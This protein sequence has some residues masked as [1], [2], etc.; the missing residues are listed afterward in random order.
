MGADSDIEVTRES[1]PYNLG[2]PRSVLQLDDA[3]SDGGYD[4]EFEGSR[5]IRQRMFPHV[6]IQTN[7]LTNRASHGPS[8]NLCLPVPHHFVVK[9]LYLRIE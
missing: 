1:L 4:A 8:Q 2:D 9:I 3:I 7:C 6:G 5:H